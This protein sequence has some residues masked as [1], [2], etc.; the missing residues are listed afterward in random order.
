MKIIQ[1]SDVPAMQSTTAMMMID[2]V[3]SRSPN[4][5]DSAVPDPEMV[6]A[7]AVSTISRLVCVTVPS[8]F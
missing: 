8:G 4:E 1:A 3:R 2:V 7:A 5:S 6:P